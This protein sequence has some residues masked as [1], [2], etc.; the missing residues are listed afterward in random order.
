LERDLPASAE[1]SAR[2]AG[3]RNRSAQGMPAPH[4]GVYAKPWPQWAVYASYFTPSLS[5]TACGAPSHCVG[6]F[7]W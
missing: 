5:S 3:L 1:A 4:Q 7:P 2:Q 6:T